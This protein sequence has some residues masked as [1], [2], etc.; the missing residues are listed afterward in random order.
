MKINDCM[1]LVHLGILAGILLVGGIYGPRVGSNV[2]IIGAYM[3]IAI[4]TILYVRKKE[5]KKAIFL[6]GLW[7]LLVIALFIKYLLK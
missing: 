6:G 3:A 2:A 7:A 4:Q 1:K 5:K